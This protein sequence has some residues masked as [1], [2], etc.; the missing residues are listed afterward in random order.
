MEVIEETD[1]V[2]AIIINLSKRKRNAYKGKVTV[3]ARDLT[4]D[5]KA[6]K[7]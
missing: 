2:L 4:D 5:E 3:T 7:A 1:D 6:G